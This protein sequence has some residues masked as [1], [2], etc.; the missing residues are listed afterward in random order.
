[1]YKVTCKMSLNLK[2]TIDYPEGS[3]S[4]W[5]HESMSPHFLECVLSG[6]G[7][8]VTVGLK[9]VWDISNQGKGSWWRILG[10]TELVVKGGVCVCVVAWMWMQM[11][12]TR[13]PIRFPIMNHIRVLKWVIYL[14]VVCWVD[15][16]A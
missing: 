9:S 12:Q 8:G 11:T 3:S 16:T 2:Y 14:S 6:G 5:V 7:R 4:I 13:F 15:K 10:D 1:M